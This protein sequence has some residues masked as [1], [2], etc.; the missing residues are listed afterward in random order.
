MN[1]I[2][3]TTVSTQKIF[4]NHIVCEYTILKLIYRS[5]DN[6]DNNICRI[7][8]QSVN[9]INNPLISV[10]KC[11]GSMNVMHMDCLKS[12]LQFK[13]QCKESTKKMSVS[14]TTSSYNC[15]ICK[16]PYPSI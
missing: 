14:Y 13:V 5:I 10:C 9:D 2:G 3:E 4:R 1:V 12:W 11:K 7:C 16:E 6:S 15:E 8:L